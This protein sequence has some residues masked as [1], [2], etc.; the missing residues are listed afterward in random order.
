M[1][2]FFPFKDKLTIIKVQK[3]NTETGWGPALALA[4]PPPLLPALGLG[5]G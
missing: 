1:E 4:Q 5:G 2:Y 3:V